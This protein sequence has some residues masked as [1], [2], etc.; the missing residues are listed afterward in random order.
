MANTMPNLLIGC[1]AGFSG[2]RTDAALPV[3][4]EL[5]DRGQPLGYLEEQLRTRF[6]GSEPRAVTVLIMASRQPVTLE[7][8]RQGLDT[9]SPELVVNA[10]DGWWEGLRQ[11][12]GRLIV[13]RE[14][15]APSSNP[16]DRLARAQRLLDSGQ[17][18]AARAEVTRLP[19]AG[20]ASAQAWPCVKAKPSSRKS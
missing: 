3:V 16:N 9:L 13:I 18:E 7:T 2:D 5:I 6:G 8:L 20:A 19:G 14:A 4:R 10:S 12:L 15:T 1:A 17:V 11:E